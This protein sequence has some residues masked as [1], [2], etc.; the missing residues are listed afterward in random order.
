MEQKICSVCAKVFTEKFAYQ[1]HRLGQKTLFFCTPFCRNAHQSAQQTCLECKVRFAPTL[2]VHVRQRGLKLDFFCSVH[3]RQRNEHPVIF[4]A[5]PPAPPTRTVAILNQKGGT[6]KTTTSVSLAAGLAQNGVK[7]LLMDLD[8][9]GSVSASLGCQSPKTM[10]DVLLKRASVQHC[11]Q[12]V[13]THLDVLT[14]NGSL[15]KAELALGQLTE[16]MRWQVMVDVLKTLRQYQY[17][18]I[19]CA[20][21]HSLINRSTLYAAGEVLIPVSCD[22]LSLLGVQQLLRTLHSIPHK[23]GKNIQITGILPTFYDV[24]CTHSLESLAALKKYFGKKTLQPI[25]VNTKLAEAVGVQ[26][27]IFEYA[28]DSAG[29]KDYLELVRYLRQSHG[30]SKSHHAA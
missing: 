7:T 24:R 3:C 1:R 8:P 30:V 10:A 25:R 19:D 23:G 16:P 20:P 6:G 11:I 12:Q 18:V 4:A 26:K 5:P 15:A 2:A 17:I 29:A 21:A 27:T 22:Y 28:P 13:R 14:A 9:Q